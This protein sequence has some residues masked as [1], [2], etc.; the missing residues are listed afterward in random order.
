M[1][2]RVYTLF[3]W[4]AYP[5]FFIIAMLIA[6]CAR[7]F[8][9]SV[10]DSPRLVWGEAPIIN[11]SYWARAMRAAGC[12]SLTFT[13]GYSYTI[14]KREDYDRVVQDHY[15]PIPVFLKY[16][17]AFFESLFRFDVF[18]YRLMASF[19]GRLHFGAWKPCC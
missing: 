4:A 3:C 19:L 11:N 15:G 13:D 8:C 14:N 1:K 12:K 7:L 9:R 5:L 18:L 2:T 10:L 16:Y 17:L 6:L